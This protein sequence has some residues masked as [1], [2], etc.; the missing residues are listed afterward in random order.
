MPLFFYFLITKLGCINDE[1]FTSSFSFQKITL[2]RTMVS[3]TIGKLVQS[4]SV[5]RNSDR[6]RNESQTY[7]R[8][9][10][11]FSGFWCVVSVADH[12]SCATL[13]SSLSL[14]DVILVVLA[15][16]RSASKRILNGRK[17]RKNGEK[18]DE[19][20]NRKNDRKRFAIK[21]FFQVYFSNSF[22]RISLLED[23]KNFVFKEIQVQ[24]WLFESF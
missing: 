1:K 9:L 15:G 6:Q 5:S 11:K 14:G 4:S 18:A 23:F 17:G 22:R 20:R 8:Q 2:E 16:I 21:K 12:R 24:R 7:F 13:C 19:Q 10:G 3:L